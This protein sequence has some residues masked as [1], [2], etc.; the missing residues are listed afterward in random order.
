MNPSTLPE[1]EFR[2]RMANLPLASNFP[3]DDSRMGNFPLPTRSRCCGLTMSCICLMLSPCLYA[4]LD[5]IRIRAAHKP[6]RCRAAR[7]SSSLRTATSPLLDETSP[8]QSWATC[9]Q[10]RPVGQMSGSSLSPERR[11]SWQRFIFRKTCS[12]AARSLHSSGK[13]GM[14]PELCQALRIIHQ[15]WLSEARSPK[16]AVRVS[17]FFAIRRP[18][19]ARVSF[20]I[21]R[22]IRCRSFCSTS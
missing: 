21:R 12:A 16:Y 6:R 13:G 22:R 3:T 20:R 2:K 9:H 7:I 14:L 19:P 4:E 5:P 17:I 11:S 15:A 1:R 8:P 10:A 18:C